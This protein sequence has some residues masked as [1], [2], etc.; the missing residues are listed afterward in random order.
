MEPSGG[1]EFSLVCMNDAGENVDYNQFLSEYEKEI[2]VD[3]NRAVDLNL[4]AMRRA[5]TL[6]NGDFD[7]F[8][9]SQCFSFLL[10][11]T[12]ARILHDN[13]K[14]CQELGIS[15][16]EVKHSTFGVLEAKN[17]L[18]KFDSLKKVKQT[19]ERQWSRKIK[20]FKDSVAQS[21]VRLFFYF[22]SE[23][24]TVT[25]IQK[26]FVFRKIVGPIWRK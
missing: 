3:L 7:K 21:W 1:S 9:G 20:S 11:T 17:S 15:A 6:Y 12:K 14:K 24:N 19:V 26:P 4:S 10:N 13:E 22:G 23:I 25:M 8:L 2:A 16:F 18:E 5:Y